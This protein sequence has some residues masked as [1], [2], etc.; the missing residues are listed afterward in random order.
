MRPEASQTIPKGL[1]RRPLWFPKVASLGVLQLAEGGAI[2]L[3][4]ELDRGWKASR[5]NDLEP[6]MLPAMSGRGVRGHLGN[7]R[8]TLSQYIR[9]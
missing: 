2:A 1:K 7:Q 3:M 8:E 5:R 6:M 4:Q 9:T